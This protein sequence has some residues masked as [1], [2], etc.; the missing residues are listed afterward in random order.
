MD[1]QKLKQIEEI[2]HSALEVAP[3]KRESFLDESCG[4]DIELRREV[5]SLLSFKQT[6]DDLLETPPEMLAAEMFAK[7]NS[8]DNIIGKDIRHYQI[9][10]LLGKGGMGEIYL[11][12]DS[13]STV[14]SP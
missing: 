6:S 3:D 13:N 1:S 7:Q 5:E 11:A 10:E 14:K 9:K 12:E 8:S 4:K 2:Y